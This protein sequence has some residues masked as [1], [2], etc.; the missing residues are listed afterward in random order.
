[1]NNCTA[2]VVSIS[3]STIFN[4]NFVLGHFP[5]LGR[6]FVQHVALGR[7]S[8]WSCIKAIRPVIRFGFQ[9]LSRT[10]PCIDRRG[11]LQSDTT[12]L[13]LR[14]R[15]NPSGFGVFSEGIFLEKLFFSE[16]YFFWI[17]FDIEKH[18]T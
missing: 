5:L 6:F 3:V 2:F 1:M 17:F 11:K 10:T 7:L 14:V 15:Q 16:K 4:I 9:F 13:L 8:I 18:S 12:F